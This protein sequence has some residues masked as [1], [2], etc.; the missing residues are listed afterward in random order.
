MILHTYYSTETLRVG[1]VVLTDN[2]F[3]LLVV[4]DTFALWADCRVLEIGRRE[5][6]HGGTGFI[7]KYGQGQEYRIRE[8]QSRHAINPQAYSSGYEH[9]ARGETGALREVATIIGAID[10]VLAWLDGWAEGARAQCPAP[11]RHDGAYLVMTC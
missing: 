11:R 8:P 10:W 5:Q 1:N 7:L 2:P 6:S 3:E 4:I 9:G